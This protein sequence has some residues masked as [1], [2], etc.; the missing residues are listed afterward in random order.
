MGFQDQD[1][2]IALRDLVAEK[3]SP[4]VAWTGAGLSKPAGLP[5]W[6][7]LKSALLKGLEDKALSFDK[8][9]VRARLLEQASSI[10]AQ[11]NNWVAFQRLKGDLGDAS[12][13]Q[14][15]EK[16][17]APAVSAKL[18]S[19]YDYIWKIGVRGV[20]NLNLDQLV[21]R[22]YFEVHDSTPNVF[23]GEQAGNMLHILKNPQPFIVNLH[24][25]TS[26]YSS[27]VFTWNELQR[28]MRT[29]GY[30]SFIESC[31]SSN[32]LV[33][34]G[35]TVDD[36]SVGG[37]L[38]WFAKKGLDTG[39][40]YW[41]S[42][43]SSLEMDNWAESVGLRVIRYSP[44]SNHTELENLFKDLVEY[45]PKEKHIIEPAYIKYHREKTNG[46]PA[47]QELVRLDSANEIRQ[48]LN[49]RATEILTEESKERYK[50]Y[51]EFYEFY[52]EAIHRAWYISTEPGNN[53]LFD[54]VLESFIAEGAFGKVYRATG[55]DGKLVAIKILQEDIRK[56]PTL[57]H[58]FRR[59]V[60]SMKLLAKNNVQGTVNYIEAS[61]IP[62]YVVMEFIE[63]PNL[64]EAADARQIEDW[65]I[66]LRISKDLVDII[67]N[68]HTVP[69]RVL[70]RD[71]RPENVMLRNFY[72]S[73]DWDVVV[74]DFDLS[75]HR[76]AIAK[77]V[78][79]GSTH[80]G[81][82]APEQAIDIPGSSTRHASV[83]SFGAG[84]TFYFLVSG[85]PPRQNQHNAN[86]WETSLDKLADLK[87]CKE[88][89][90]IPRRYLR[91]IAKATK[92]KQHER[93]DMSQIQKELGL[94]QSA[95]L[96]P[97][98]VTSAELLAEEIA[99]RSQELDNYGWEETNR[100]IHKEF[101]NGRTIEL[102]GDEVA[103]KVIMHLIWEDKGRATWQNIYKKMQNH[104]NAAIATLKKVGWKV[105]FE[106][107]DR[108]FSI[109]ASISKDRILS[110]ID[111]IS[112]NL[113]SALSHM[114]K[115]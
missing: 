62:A 93:W 98:S 51:S 32:V 17:L 106:S 79:H 44:K 114:N 1:S 78:K 28:L 53:L 42:D 43:N 71:I 22:A 7:G 24:G 3:V 46:I 54:Y 30:L 48:I 81:Y 110:N 77:S 5:S 80:Q 73:A 107:G 96:N 58:S 100:A 18:P 4:I 15:I 90:S 10:E 34:V 2:Y 72:I 21:N 68:A 66:R 29:P 39:I 70:H 23:Y 89:Q 64:F 33:F 65:D 92:E 59:G 105:Q 35:I 113:D 12:F 115:L 83:D 55:Q 61:E 11:S 37:H 109:K 86:D 14:I 49:G 74:L 47:P 9:R 40:H 102:F 50:E 56:D 82:I 84:M 69:E 108:T 85:T 75:W 19:I 52:D 112:E 63:G 99:A 8:E 88:W 60:N 45:V 20:L 27:W 111:T 38:E 31:A 103:S 6:T 104:L 101:L 76:G 87:Q 36:I 57:L 91:L 26:D 95:L 16:Q 94:L 13:R 67:R 41:I 97:D 25:V